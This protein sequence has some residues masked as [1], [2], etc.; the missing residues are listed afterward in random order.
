MLRRRSI[1]LRI[2]VLVLVPVVGLLGLYAEVLSLTVGKVLTL[3][4]EASIRDLVALPVADVQKQLAAERGDALQF[5]ARPGRVDMKL[6]L[7]QG[8]K[9]DKAISKFSAAV[10]R[11]L[12]SGP[13][14]KE[15]GAFLSWQAQL[16]KVHDLRGSVVS[17]GLTRIEAA[18]AY[19]RILGGGDNVLNQAIIPVLSGPLGLQ[20]ADLLTMAKAAQALGEESDLVRAGLIAGSFSAEDLM[21]INQLAVQHQE[22]TAQ[23]LPDLNPAIR[24]YFT[25]M[26]PHSAVSRLGAMESSLSAGPAAASQVTLQRWTSAETSYRGGFRSAL[27]K[28]TKTLAQQATSQATDLVINLL[29]I[30]GVGLIAILAAIMVGIVLGR[31]LIRQLSD[32]RESAVKL[33]TDQLPSAISR[34][35]AGDDLSVGAEVPQLKP[36]SDEIGQVR[37]A[38]NT[39]ARTAIGAAVDEIK[40]RQGVNDVF[41]SLARRNQSLLTRQLQLL[42][43][44][45]R[46]VHDPEELADLFRVD[47]MTTRMRRHAEGLLIVAGGSSGRTWREPVPIVDVM[48]AAAAEVEDYTRVRV[49]SRTSAALAGHA[50]ADVIHLL[51]ELLENAATFSPANTP[52]RVD[53]ERVGRGVVIEIEDRGLGMSAD[54]LAG[55]NATLADPPLFDLS[56][57]DQ[58]GLFIA[59]QLGKR[60]DVRITLRSSA[61]GG[62]TAV[63]LIPT[64][65]IIDVELEDGLA[66]GIRELGGRPVP[67]LPEGT[68]EPVMTLTAAAP[69][70]AAPGE[71]IELDT[72]VAA[73]ERVADGP[74]L[75]GLPDTPSWLSEPVNAEHSTGEYSAWPGAV[76]LVSGPLPASTGSAVSGTTSS[77]VT[78]AGAAGAKTTTGP[79]A[80]G[81]ESASAFTSGSAAD[82]PFAASQQG[83]EAAGGPLQS[84]L[85]TRRPGTTGLTWGENGL[86]GSRWASF[87]L[88][89]AAAGSS[90][91]TSDNP[92]RGPLPAGPSQAGADV[93]GAQATGRPDSP[94]AGTADTAAEAA[95][96]SATAEQLSP[97][98][99]AGPPGAPLV[100]PEELDGLPVRIRQANL[101][102]QLRK[103]G[104]PAEPGADEPGAPSPEA[105]R[106]TMAALQ[107]GWQR[108]RSGTSPAGLEPADANPADANPADAE[109]A[110]TG[111]AEAEP[112]KTASPAEAAM[113]SDSDADAYAEAAGS[114]ETAASPDG[115]GPADDAGPSDDAGP[116]ASTQP[117]P[118]REPPATEEFRT[119]PSPKQAG[120][121]AGE[122]GSE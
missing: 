69:A 102:P 80:G 108:G 120:D 4:Q 10:Q 36:G 67:E 71:V 75:A 104:A 98:G 61:Y 90:A 113:H 111:P 89:R 59:G 112:A 58:L 18:D 66:A 19:S 30:A 85:P 54:Q 6:L 105:A 88:G 87:P 9:T 26:I 62:V 21:L 23:T 11:G 73:A 24:S 121:Q 29:I 12:A 96:S 74:G 83:T 101:A 81:T 117:A 72:R 70:T 52:V 3:R 34:L 118:D 57:S 37:E 56:G 44:M 116:A 122:G 27:L 119:T 100:S 65:L 49:N 76:P 68:L 99:L 20:A 78:D 13:V 39:A 84:D 40:I 50:V 95:A 8:T 17:I 22:Q 107:L 93:W 47:H 60:H 31:G 1:R 5:L 115:T 35:R 94:A 45:E 15:R 77:A 33:S 91:T 43:S 64:E 53:G 38:F 14:P 103:P 110:D 55:I 97:A 82:G 63:V 48:R 106:S 42:D 46:R 32:L 7:R 51:A 92:W 86:A 16:K 25:T 2:I 114:A 79:V 109:P 41:R 28:A